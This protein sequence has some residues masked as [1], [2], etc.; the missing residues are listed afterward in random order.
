MVC[1]LEFVDIHCHIL[2]G[3]DDGSPDPETSVSMAE[4]AAGSGVAAICATVHSL[5]F[6]DGYPRRREIIPPEVYSDALHFLRRGLRELGIP[7][8]ILTGMEV[9]VDGSFRRDLERQLYFPLGGTKNL[10]IE[11]PFDVSPGEV[12]GAADAA[13]RCGYTPVVAHPER[14]YFL[15][16]EPELSD[17]L[18][19]AGCLLQ[20][21]KGSFFGSFGRNAAEAAGYML[22]RGLL[23]AVASDAHSDG[24]RTPSFRKIASYLT[25]KTGAETAIE[26]LRDGPA[27]L[28]GFDPSRKD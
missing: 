9:Y 24:V 20:A 21:N 26:L 7:V 11:F 1:G 23:S 19:E 14:Y 13:L 22:G 27:R 4:I 25:E 15:C 28:C 5:G 6:G 16:D 12:F 8:K 17:G 10:L 18:V 3:L 2:P